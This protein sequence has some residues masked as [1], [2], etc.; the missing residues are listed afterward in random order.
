MKSADG[1]PEVSAPV[2]MICTIGPAEA[3]KGT[4]GLQIQEGWIF[5][6]TG[7]LKSVAPPDAVVFRQTNPF[8]KE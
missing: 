1:P 7:L 3:G 2:F 5:W 4:L 6:D 8:E